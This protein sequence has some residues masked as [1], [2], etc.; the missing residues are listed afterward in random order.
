MEEGR[1]GEG[2]LVSIK[3]MLLLEPNEAEGPSSQMY[4][5]PLSC[6]LKMA[7]MINLRYILP[8][9]RTCKSSNLCDLCWLKVRCVR[10]SEWRR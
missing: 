4:L 2:R 9:T 6:T 10:S 5:I 1:P 3:K 8:H 7:K